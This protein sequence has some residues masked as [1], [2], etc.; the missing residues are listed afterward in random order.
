MYVTTYKWRSGGAELD[1]PL[2]HWHIPSDPYDDPNVT[3][4]FEIILYK[5]KFIILLSNRTVTGI[6]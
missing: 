2:T 6:V 5:I 1:D 4:K 3:L